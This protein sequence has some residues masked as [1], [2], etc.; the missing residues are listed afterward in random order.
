M[1]RVLA[2]VTVLVALPAGAASAANAFVTPAD[3]ERADELLEKRWA[4]LGP[5]PISRKRVEAARARINRKLLARGED[6]L[7]EDAPAFAS[8]PVATAAR[9][10][11]RHPWFKGLRGAAAVSKPAID[12]RTSVPAMRAQ[13]SQASRLIICFFDVDGGATGGSIFDGYFISYFGRSLCSEPVEQS[14]H[15]ELWLPERFGTPQL[16]G[17]IGGNGLFLDIA[18]NC[19]A[20]YFFIYQCLSGDRFESDY[21]LGQRYRTIFSWGGYVPG[22][23]TGWVPYSVKTFFSCQGWFTASL[24]CNI[25]NDFFDT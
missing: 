19:A 25:R 2:V 9:I 12:P 10:R 11:A 15:A 22:T 4:R 7:A 21:L 13:R 16:D 1:K 18:P 14:G 24:R 3:A 5:P 17:V 20:A 8:L 23:A 6:P